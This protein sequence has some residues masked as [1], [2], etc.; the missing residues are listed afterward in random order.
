MKTHSSI[1]SFKSLLWKY[2]FPYLLLLAVGLVIVHLLFRNVIIAKTLSSGTAKVDRIKANNDPQEIPILGS[3]RAEGS[4]I[5]DSLGKNYFNYGMAGVQDDVWLYFLK[6]ELSKKR[7][8]PI[9][10]NLDS[11]GLQ[12]IQSGLIYWLFN[13]NDS[14][15]QSFIGNEWRTIHYVPVVRNF[16]FF[17]THIANFVNEQLEIT[18]SRNKGA[19]LELKSLSKKEFDDAIEK[20]KATKMVVT[21]DPGIYSDLFKTLSSTN[22]RKVILV[23]PPYHKAYLNSIQNPE[24]VNE[25]HTQLDA[26]PNV[27]VLDYSNL[28]L[29]DNLFYNT[30]HLNKSGAIVFNRVIKQAID[31]VLALPKEK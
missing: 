12:R 1:S 7:E 10:I 18:G 15:I 21:N 24:L 26:L 8:T 13:T 2:I 27:F 17:E 16:G 6:I 20:R 5:P 25:L 14:T 23:V 11:D 4:F 31:S 30:T 19:I 29:S 9:I 3:S 28:P 22:G